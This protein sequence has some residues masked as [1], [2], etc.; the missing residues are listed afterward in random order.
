MLFVSR[1]HIKPQYRTG[2]NVVAR[3]PAQQ[4]RA[5]RGWKSC[6]WPQNVEQVRGQGGAC[7]NEL[8]CNQGAAG[9]CCSVQLFLGWLLPPISKRRLNVTNALDEPRQVLGFKRGAMVRSGEFLAQSKV[10]LDDASPE[11]DRSKR[12][13]RTDRV[14]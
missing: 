10:L 11:C 7:R 14:V 12:H 13:L 9:H 5:H 1:Q 2:F 3:M 6:T 4:L 8:R